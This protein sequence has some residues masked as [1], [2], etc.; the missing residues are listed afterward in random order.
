MN[1]QK[2]SQSD[3]KTRILD[4]AERLFAIEGFQRTSIKQLACEAR[5]NQAAVNYYFGSKATLI[6]KVIERRLRPI[7]QQRIERLEAVRQSATRKGCRP[8]AEDV[9]RAFI[10]P[11]FTVNTPMQEKRYLLALAGC[12]FAEPDATIRAIFVRQFQPAFMLLFRTMRK[13]LP[14]LPGGVLFLRLHFAIGAMIHCLHL[15]SDSLAPPDLFSQAA[16]PK[17]IMNLLLDFVTRG[18]CTPCLRKERQ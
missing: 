2:Q 14:G 10:E 13:T 11:A 7:N 4:V 12:A 17:P 15:C 9:L 18:V 1:V 6:E 8:L 5:V 3:T 16:D